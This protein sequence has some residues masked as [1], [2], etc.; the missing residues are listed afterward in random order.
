MRKLLLITIPIACLLISFKADN[1]A[2]VHFM[3]KSWNQ[4][5][6]I[7]HVN[8]K[9]IFVFVADNAS[10]MNQDK[11][12][13]VFTK[14]SVGDYF[15]K[16]FVCVKIDPTSATNHVLLSKWGVTQFPSVLFFSSNGKRMT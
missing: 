12:S 15:N 9:P 2:G 11:A 3:N 16:Q 6:K 13:K 5:S 7:A 1:Q 10:F 8:Q 14:K 4:V